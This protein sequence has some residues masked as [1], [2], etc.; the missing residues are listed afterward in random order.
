MK[1]Q[2]GLLIYFGE[3]LDDG[4]EVMV[5]ESQLSHHIAI[6]PA[7]TRL[8]AG[9]AD[10]HDLYLLRN[11]A[12]E[13]YAKWQQSEVAGLFGAR[14][15]LLPHQL[16][17]AHTVAERYHPRVLL[18]DEVGLGKTI[19]AGMIM[20]RR[21]LTGR[22]QRV[23]VVVPESLRN[24][25]LVEMRRRFAL[26]F[27]V[28]DDERCEQLQ[29]EHDNPF[30]AEQLIIVSTDFVIQQRWQEALL[31]AEFDLL[32]VDEAHH[33]QP[34]T[35]GYEQL[36]RLSETINDV[37]LL[38]AT[39]EQEGSEGHFHRL[40][41]LDPNRFDSLESFTEQ[42][43][44]YQQLASEAEKLSGD[45]LDRLL[46]RHSTGRVMFRNRRKHVGGFPT[47]HLLVHQLPAYTRKAA[48]RGGWKIPE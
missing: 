35:Q 9:N 34:E 20:Q 17:V 29:D 21:L 37:L 32:V 13:Y 42:Q 3:R 8:V 27:S 11:Q 22:D 26:T 15:G 14:V 48:S 43:R 28:F 1:E 45:Q 31:S 39:P 10:R 38:T 36:Q 2:G 16:Y 23:L 24:Q 5:P 7:L 12:S 18:A 40:R 6:N 47:R 41:L 4:S 44:H 46:D 30:F 25:W 19:E 33:M